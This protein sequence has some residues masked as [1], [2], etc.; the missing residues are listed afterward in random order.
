MLHFTM[1]KEDSVQP[2]QMR[3]LVFIFLVHKQ[4]YQVVSQQCP[5]HVVFTGGG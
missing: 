4:Q 5:Y 1:N 2:V 3:W